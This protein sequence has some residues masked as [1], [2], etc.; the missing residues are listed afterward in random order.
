[1]PSPRMTSTNSPTTTTD[2][3]RFMRSLAPLVNHLAAD[4]RGDN[5]RISDAVA[6]GIRQD[7]ARE[8]DEI[9][10]LA[11]LERPAVSLLER[12]ESARQRV[13]LDRLGGGDLLFREP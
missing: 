6:L 9:G 10:Q 11:G 8:H 3:T 1:M 12:G 5:R 2:T 13:R 7:V 4:D